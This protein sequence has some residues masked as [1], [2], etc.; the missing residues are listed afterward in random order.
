MGRAIMDAL[1]QHPGVRFRTIL[2]RP[3]QVAPLRSELGASMELIS[4]LDELTSRPDLVLECA[5]HQAVTTLVPSL[6]QQGITNIIA[7]VGVLSVE[8]VPERLEDAALQ[9]KSRLIF[10]PGAIGGIDVLAAARW[11]ALKSVSYVGRKPPLA[12]RGTLAEDRVCLSD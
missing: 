3:Q 6:L 9:G 5:G 8:G 4:S 12:W 10:V 7:S 11:G 2:T 1:S